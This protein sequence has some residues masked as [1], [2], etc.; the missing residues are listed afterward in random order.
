MRFVTLARRFF[1]IGMMVIVCEVNSNLD[2][3]LVGLFSKRYM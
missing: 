3:N 1:G 2:I